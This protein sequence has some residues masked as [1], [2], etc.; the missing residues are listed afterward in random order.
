M[1]ETAVSR[2]GVL[3]A[4]AAAGGLAVASSATPAAAASSNAAAS[5]RRRGAALRLHLLKRATFGPT[6]ASLHDIDKRGFQHW[7][8]R[9]LD[10][11]SIHDPE[12]DAVRRLY[13]ELRWSIPQARANIEQFSWDLMFT[14]GQATLAQAAWSRRQLFEVMCDFW[15][16]HLNVTNPSDNVWDNR[17]HYERYVIRAHA[18]G[19]FSDMLVASAKHPAMLQYLNNADSTKDAPNENYGR[20][21]LELHTVGISAGYTE[22]MMVDSAR[23]MT[24][25]TVGEDGNYVYEPSIHWTGK[26][27]ILDFSNANTSPNG[28]AL[29]VRYLHHLAMHPSTAH[30]IAQKLAIR[31]VA[32]E[33]PKA[34]VRRLAHVY[35]ANGTAIK[36]VLRALFAS[37]EFAAAPEKVRRPY[38]DLLATM[39]VLGVGLH[40]GSDTTAARSG[41]ESLY[42]M[43]Q[44]A[45]QAPGAWDLPNGYPDVATAWQSAAG[46]LSRWNFHQSLAAGWWPDKSHVHVADCRSFLP[47]KLPAT[48]GGLI[49]HLSERL[50][51]RRLPHA[52]RTAAL[53]FCEAH[54]S[55]PLSSSSEWVSWRLPYLCALILDSPAHLVR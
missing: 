2:R 42:W 39:R 27:R 52:H 28:E 17:H 38:E 25:F 54:A 11:A 22:A 44:S 46:A 45:G 10:P 30:Q 4:A 31:F 36:P 29:A 9:Q 49:D 33:P 47:H 1:A 32:D 50:L 37:A 24:G 43:V 18:L 20:E 3:A 26:L 16:N 12:G 48:Y 53:R 6:P 8:E 21:L 14:L 13:P 23:M 19:K 51:F 35:L 55:T 15:A 5:H 40:R 34:L 41:L 7:L